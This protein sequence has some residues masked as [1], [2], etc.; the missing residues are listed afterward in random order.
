MSLYF[1]PLL[2]ILLIETKS[3]PFDIQDKHKII[4][5]IKKY[6]FI[7]NFIRRDIW[8]KFGEVKWNDPIMQSQVYFFRDKNCPLIALFPGFFE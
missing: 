8:H 3:I 4:W 5:K 1:K 2:D 6:I 7:Y